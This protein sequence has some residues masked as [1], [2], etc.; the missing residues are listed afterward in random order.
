MTHT[1]LEQRV[2]QQLGKRNQSPEA[3]FMRKTILLAYNDFPR[4]SPSKMQDL[5]LAGCMLQ[6][7]SMN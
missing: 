6:N 5:A 7:P 4:K 1:Q 3:I 2:D